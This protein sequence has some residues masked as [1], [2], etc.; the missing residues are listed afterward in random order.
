MPDLWYVIMPL[1]NPVPGALCNAAWVLHDR[2]KWVTSSSCIRAQSVSAVNTAVSTVG[3]CMT[4]K[5]CDNA[6]IT[7][8]AHTATAR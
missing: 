6:F 4:R 3:M 7:S 5:V 1:T 8:C 2:N